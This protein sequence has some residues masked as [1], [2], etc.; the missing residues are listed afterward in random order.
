MTIAR[1]VDVLRRSFPDLQGDVAEGFWRARADGFDL[2]VMADIDQDRLRIMVPVAEAERGDSDLL[3]VLLVAN[4][5]LALDARYAVQD[6]VVWCT[7]LHR[8]SWLSEYEVD[9]A[10]ASV[11]TLA[12]NTGTTFSNREPVDDVTRSRN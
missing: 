7:F 8:L 5:D 4:Y 2:Y 10:L 1:L 9:H 6:D 12:K 3:W 11:L